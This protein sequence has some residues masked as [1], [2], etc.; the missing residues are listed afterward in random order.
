MHEH[1]TGE[2]LNNE[3][4]KDT[5]NPENNIV[6]TIENDDM[7]SYVPAP[8]ST[9]E[10][11][12]ESVR[13]D[14]WLKSAKIDP[15]AEIQKPPVVLKIGEAD[16][17][18]LGD[19]SCITGKAKS[20]KTFLISM[21]ISS[22]LKGLL[23]IIRGVKYENKK[24]AIW[25]DTEQ[26]KYHI[27]K[28]FRRA[29]RLSENESLHDIEVYG[30]RPHTPEERVKII[31]RVLIDLN[32]EKDISFVVIDGIR[33]LITDINDPKQATEIT[34]WLMKITE[35]ADLHICTVL[36]QNKGDKNARGH[37]GTEIVNKAQS[38]LSV[39]KKDENISLV[40]AECLR[41]KEFDPFAFSINEDG[42]PYVLADYEISKQE[43]KRKI[44]PFDV[45]ENTHREIFEA[46]FSRAKEYKRSD[47]ISQIILEYSKNMVDFGESKAREFL[48]HAQNLKIIQHNGAHTKNVRYFL[49][50]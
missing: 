33:D 4:Y 20:K 11:V 44:V 29:L 49:H 40:S 34:T 14:E 24:R 25:F 47:L 1:N 23:N 10:N 19:F 48:N 2:Y 6:F 46:I 38:V 5:T 42:L 35:L 27:T 8:E 41:D 17:C 12:T 30:L 13:V 31:Q 16:V 36:H 32:A 28:A 3:Q 39:E 50:K 9:P 7:E 37:L 43:S 45:A 21:F 18:Y 26:S 22:F 15:T